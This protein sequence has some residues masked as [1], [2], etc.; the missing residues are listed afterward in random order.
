ML[1]GFCLRRLIALP[2]AYLLLGFYSLIDVHLH[3]GFQIFNPFL[4]EPAKLE[5]DQSRD[6]IEIRLRIQ[7]S[8]FSLSTTAESDRTCDRY[9]ATNKAHLG[10]VWCIIPVGI[11]R[12]VLA[13]LFG[14]FTI[15]LH[16]YASGFTLGILPR[17]V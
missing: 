8:T 6:R 17:K 9:D 7:C 12:G 15:R 4:L 14:A 3:R 10:Y 2:I 11:M 16:P 13:T 5:L 1:T